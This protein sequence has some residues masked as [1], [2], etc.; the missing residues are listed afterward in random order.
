LTANPARASP[1]ESARERRG[2]SRDLALAQASATASSFCSATDSQKGA[3]RVVG[4][5]ERASRAS[6][7]S[8]AEAASRCEIG[9]AP[10]WRHVEIHPARLPIG[11]RKSWTDGRAIKGSRL[12]SRVRRR[13]A[14]PLGVAIGR[15]ANF[16]GVADE[17][18]RRRIEVIRP[19]LQPWTA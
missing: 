6:R 7:T 8:D 16:S 10:R 19:S 18:E 12:V 4:E 13:K 17:H 14:A 11:R 3:F 5:T 9:R 1:S 2:A 15:G